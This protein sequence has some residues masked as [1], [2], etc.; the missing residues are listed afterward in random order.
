MKAGYKSV[1]E[2]YRFEQ[3][4]EVGSAVSFDR[5][6]EGSGV[7]PLYFRFCWIVERYLNSV[8]RPSSSANKLKNRVSSDDEN[9]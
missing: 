3:K 5:I 9:G 7:A 4:A 6:S 1:R 2:Q 8:I